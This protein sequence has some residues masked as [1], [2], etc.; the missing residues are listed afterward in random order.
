VPRIAAFRGIVIFMYHDEHGVAHF[1]AKHGNQQASY[2][3]ESG[4][5]SAEL[6][7]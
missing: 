6:C 2:E 7:R 3:I 1:H 5:C 4:C